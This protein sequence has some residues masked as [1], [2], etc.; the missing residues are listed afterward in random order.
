MLF[1]LNLGNSPDAAP[2]PVPS[3][4]TTQ[5]GG[6][7][8]PAYYPKKRKF[9]RKDE[10]ELKK[11]LLSAVDD[12]KNAQRKLEKKADELKRVANAAEGIRNAVDEAQ[13]VIRQ[14]AKS[15][16]I[17]WA[18]AQRKIKELEDEEDM[19]LIRIALF[20]SS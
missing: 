13:K 20:L 10:K 5:G 18:E 2:P 3:T 19:L 11:L 16:E 1:F 9:N 15:N 17:K 8:L 14:Q 6:R 7:F 4:P 12:E